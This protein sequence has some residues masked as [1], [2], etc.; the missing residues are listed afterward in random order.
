MSDLQRLVACP[1][2]LE[3][4]HVPTH[5]EAWWRNDGV[6]RDPVTGLRWLD[7]VEGLVP[8]LSDPATRGCLKGLLR[9][10]STVHLRPTECAK[11]ICD[12]PD[13]RRHSTRLM[14]SEGAALAAALLVQWGAP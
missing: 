6:L 11:V 5:E 14:D 1:E 2:F 3:R 9:G 7:K 12:A 4:F 8:D 10:A 13:G